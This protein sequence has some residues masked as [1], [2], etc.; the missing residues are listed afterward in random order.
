MENKFYTKYNKPA[1]TKSPAGEI[2]R[3]LYSSRF[4]KNGNVE[5]YEIGKQNV[6]EY[7]QSHAESV[8]INVILAKFAAG[9]TKVLQ[10]VESRYIDT[11]G[12]PTTYAEM[13]NVVIGAEQHFDSLSA[14]EKSKYGNSFERYLSS[15][16][17]VVQESVETEVQGTIKTDEPEVKE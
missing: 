13:L 9:D 11:I 12:L 14:D 8:D 1:G 10:K 4:D 3:T 7:I 2:M 5:I 17:Q 6:Y 16:D 15:L